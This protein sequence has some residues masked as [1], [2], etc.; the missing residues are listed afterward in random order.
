MEAAGLHVETVE[1]A[2]QAEQMLK[3]TNFDLITLDLNMPG[4]TGEEW[5][6]QIRRQGVDTPIAIISNTHASQTESVMRL[7]SEG[8]QAYLEKEDLTK[9]PDLLVKSLIPL[10]ETARQNINVKSFRMQRHPPV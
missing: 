2:T 7:L 9:T 10:I 4:Q 1:S 3:T 8:A 6:K 5:L